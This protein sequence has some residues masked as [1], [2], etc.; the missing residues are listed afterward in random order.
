MRQ[1]VGRCRRPCVEEEHHVTRRKGRGSAG[2]C[3]GHGAQ[4]DTESLSV[5]C[6]VNELELNKTVFQKRKQ[7]LC[8]ITY[9]RHFTLSVYVLPKFTVPSEMGRAVGAH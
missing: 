7:F 8:I 6:V 4:G 5:N 3:T 9:I 2:A 1:C